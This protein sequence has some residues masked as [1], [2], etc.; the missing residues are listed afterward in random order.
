LGVGDWGL[1]LVLD[2][3]KFAGLV[4]NFRFAI[5]DFGLGAKICLGT[6]QNLERIGRKGFHKITNQTMKRMALS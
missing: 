4:L 2:Q 6:G 5:L 3:I 1:G